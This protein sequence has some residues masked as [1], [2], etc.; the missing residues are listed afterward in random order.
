MTKRTVFTTVSPLPAG[1]SREVVIDF[2]HNHIDMIDLNPLVI[3][4]HPIDP[5][6]KAD[7]GERECVWYSLTDKIDYLPGGKVSGDISYTCAF[8]DLANGIQTH[9]RA[10]LG[11]DIREKWT[12]CGS[13]PSEPPEPVELGLGAPA[14]GLYLRE[15]VDLRCNILM[16]S[17]VKKNLKR[18]HATLVEKLVE[19]AKLASALG[20]TGFDARGSPPRFTQTTTPPPPPWSPPSQAQ[21]SAQTPATTQTHPQERSRATRSPPPQI[22]SAFVDG[23]QRSQVSSFPVTT[24]PHQGSPP[25]RSHSQYLPHAQTRIHSQ[26]PP[27]LRAPIHTPPPAGPTSPPYSPP[28]TSIPAGPTTT[29]TACLDPTCYPAPL[30][31][32]N[33]SVS[34]SLT[35]RESTS[36]VSGSS[37]GGST[38]RNSSEYQH[39]HYPHLS[40]YSP[41]EASSSPDEPLPPQTPPL[42]GTSGLLMG[43]HQYESGASGK[44]EVVD[45]HPPV[46]RPGG[47]GG[48]GGGMTYRLNGPFIAE[49]E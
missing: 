17:F 13:L 45:H 21:A 24:P 3:E 30:R 12:L 8:H 39:P 40:P 18:S 34:S 48:G 19:V 14:T 5:P 27:V 26:C 43:Y 2:L 33:I 32:R 7:P 4:R 42:P 10:P 29:T 23:C 46:L 31:I 47:G 41:T 36:F 1:V 11:V 37:G 22:G 49:L 35:G 15:D 16:T 25:Y 9:C 28:L 44:E 38:N 6:A 20:K